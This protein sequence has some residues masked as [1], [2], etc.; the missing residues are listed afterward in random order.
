MQLA[1]IAAADGAAL[2]A[3]PGL[4]TVV[5]A[6]GDGGATL[7][8]G[9]VTGVPAGEPGDAV[10]PAPHP[11]SNAAVSG[12]ASSLILVCIRGL[13]SMRHAV[14]RAASRPTSSRCAPVPSV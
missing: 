7:A 11:A 5:A 10:A 3:W 9:V 14:R 12:T 13:L 8:T 6:A 4:A 1:T 2:A